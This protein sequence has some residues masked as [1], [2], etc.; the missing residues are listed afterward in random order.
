[1]K[2]TTTVLL[3]KFEE[4]HLRPNRVHH[5]RDGKSRFIW[6][7]DNDD[8]RYV[9]LVD[10]ARSARVMLTLRDGWRAMARVMED[11]ELVVMLV[12]QYLRM[13]GPG[14]VS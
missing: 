7:V 4:L 14:V 8:D 13:L 2:V 6:Y 9:E 1:M 3:K 12:Q 5:G 10:S 11:Q